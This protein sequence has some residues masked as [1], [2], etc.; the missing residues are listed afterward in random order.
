MSSSILYSA[1][2]LH[3]SSVCSQMRSYQSNSPDGFPPFFNSDAIPNIENCNVDGVPIT[4]G[5][6]PRKHI[7]TYAGGL[8]EGHPWGDALCPFNTG[9]FKTTSTSFVDNDSY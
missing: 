7:W 5:T 1:Y 3:Y 2:G 8:S 6:N 9:I 4:Y